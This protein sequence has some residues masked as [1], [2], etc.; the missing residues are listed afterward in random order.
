VAGYLF[1]RHDL[2]LSVP[3][4]RTVAL[5]TLIV[6]GLYLVMA[7]E[8]GG[9]R[10]RSALVAGMCAVMAGLYVLALVVPA[11]RSFFALTAL[12]PGMLATALVASGVSISALALC[13]FSLRV[14]PAQSL[15]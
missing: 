7:L 14:E 13:G 12:D 3:D 15:D 8:A 11:T 9:S 5:T 2:D 4:S 6:C 10:R 1:A